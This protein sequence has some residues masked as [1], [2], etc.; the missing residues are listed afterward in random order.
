MVLK[1][2]SGYEMHAVPA[3]LQADQGV[4]DRLSRAN[5]PKQLLGMTSRAQSRRVA[6]TPHFE[7][8]FRNGMGAPA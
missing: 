1:M 3:T 7:P 8:T 6:L 4:A 2:K 5:D